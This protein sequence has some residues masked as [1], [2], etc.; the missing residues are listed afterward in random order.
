MANSSYNWATKLT[1]SNCAKF[2][3]ATSDVASSNSYK[4]ARTYFYDKY[5][6]DLEKLVGW[7]NISETDFD[8]ICEY[9]FFSSFNSSI[10]LNFTPSDYDRAY[11]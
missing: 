10:K 5:K 4:E 9:I 2:G 3:S 6:K 8:N 1:E 7:S 11:C